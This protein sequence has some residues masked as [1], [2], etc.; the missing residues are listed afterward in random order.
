M[1][2]LINKLLLNLL[3]EE[4]LR[5]AS[6]GLTGGRSYADIE[7]MVAQQENKVWGPEDVKI[8]FFQINSTKPEG[9]DLRTYAPHL[10]RSFGWDEN[11]SIAAIQANPDETKRIPYKPNVFVRANDGFLI[12]GFVVAQN[13]NEA[14]KLLDA[15]VQELRS[16]DQDMEKRHGGRR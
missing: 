10:G 11:A 3:K 12:T 7:R 9:S 13:D 14:K 15:K 6:A 1:K 5:Y 4:D 8:W 2:N 16:H